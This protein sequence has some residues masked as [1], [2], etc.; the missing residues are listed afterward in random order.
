MLILTRRPLEAICIGDEITV[1]VL[2]VKGTHVRLG[3]KA[4]KH[5]RVDREEVRERIDA[6]RDTER[7]AS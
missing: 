7:A 6:E 3:I 5:V 2:G 4:P 1:T